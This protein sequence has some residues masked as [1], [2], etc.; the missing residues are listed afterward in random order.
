MIA[1]V[2]KAYMAAI[3][4]AV[5]FVSIYLLLAI[6][7]FGSSKYHWSISYKIKSKLDKLK[8]ILQISFGSPPLLNYEQISSRP[9]RFLFTET[10]IKIST[11]YNV[12]QL[13][14]EIHRS[15]WKSI[16]NKYGLGSF[17]NSQNA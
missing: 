1:S 12:C 3:A 9:V 14:S 8:L 6:I 13:I 15:L 16:E 7:Y 10:P 4:F 17:A 2:G 5:T 11:D